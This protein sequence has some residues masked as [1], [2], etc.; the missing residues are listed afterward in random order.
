MSYSLS[1]WL[2]IKTAA[3]LELLC[4]VNERNRSNMVKLLIRN[5]ARDLE[6]ELVK[7][8]A[9]SPQVAQTVERMTV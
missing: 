5:A 2:D 7:P 9:T 3:A 1:V 4:L 6:K 8:P